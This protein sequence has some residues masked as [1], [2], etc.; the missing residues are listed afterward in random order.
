MSCVSVGLIIP[1]HVGPPAL[2]IPSTGPLPPG[3]NTQAASFTPTAQQQHA[4][5]PPPLTRAPTRDNNTRQERYRREQQPTQQPTPPSIHNVHRHRDPSKIDSFVN[6]RTQ[7][8]SR[9]SEVAQA[10]APPPPPSH[11]LSMVGLS[12]WQPAHGASGSYTTTTTEHRR[13][14]HRAHTTRGEQRMHDRRP[15]RRQGAVA[16]RPAQS[17]APRV[18]IQL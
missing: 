3:L 5:A 1:T 6:I 13:S 8:G 18:D 4:N 17:V 14:I 11:R 15:L 9:V 10:V 16:A 7:P 2:D 12:S